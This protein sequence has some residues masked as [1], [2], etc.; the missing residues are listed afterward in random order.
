MLLAS[1]PILQLGLL[2]GFI[3]ALV[4]FARYLNKKSRKRKKR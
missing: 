3:L 4:L 1:G 2:V